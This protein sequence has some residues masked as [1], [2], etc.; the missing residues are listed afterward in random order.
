MPILTGIDGSQRMS[1]SLGNYIGV[2]DA[3][4]EM[5]GKVMRIP[6]PLMGDYYELV[7]R[8][9]PPDGVPPN[10]AKRKLARGIVERFHDPSAAERAEEHFERLFVRHEAPEEVEEIALARDGDVHLPALLAEGFGLSRSEARRLLAQGGVRLDGEVLPGEPL[11]VDPAGLDG[12]VLQV[13]KRRHKRVR[14]S[15]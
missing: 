15:G 5:F 11:D 10:E 2:T 7:L 8:R 1:K 9:P 6:D 12:R 4:E 13:G 14:V 3:P